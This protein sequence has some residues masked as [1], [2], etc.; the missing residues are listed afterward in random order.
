MA[1]NNKAE[2]KITISDETKKAARAT[3]ELYNRIDSQGGFK[4]EKGGRASSQIGGNLKL[5]EQL[6]NQQTLSKTE[7]EGFRKALHAASKAL[8]EYA[9]SITTLSDDANKLKKQISDLSEKYNKASGKL[10]TAQTRQNTA[11][12]DLKLGYL[13]V[14]PNT[15]GDLNDKFANTH[16]YKVKKNGDRYS[17]PIT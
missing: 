16:I 3:K 8:T 15:I 14:N 7:Y 1:T 11:I 4:G 2:L 12:G 10:S 13:N 5:V 6:R 17:R 9:A